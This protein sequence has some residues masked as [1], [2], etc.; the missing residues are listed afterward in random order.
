MEWGASQERQ[1]ETVPVS[2]LIDFHVMMVLE[3]RK[4]SYANVQTERASL[5]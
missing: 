4:K 5:R 1:W 3:K 2:P